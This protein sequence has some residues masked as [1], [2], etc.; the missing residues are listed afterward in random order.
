MGMIKTGHG[1]G[2]QI[3][4]TTETL[5]KTK[6]RKCGAVIMDAEDPAAPELCENCLGSE[7]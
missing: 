6:C 5:A 4:S 7:E 2:E 1:D 3:L